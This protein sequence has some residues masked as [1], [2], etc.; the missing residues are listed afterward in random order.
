MWPIST[1][2]NKPDRGHAVVDFSHQPL[3]GTVMMAK[4]RSH[5]PVFGFRQFS[6]SPA[7]PKGEPSFMAMA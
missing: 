6:H 4:V 7:R 2:V 5:S 3:E 1:R